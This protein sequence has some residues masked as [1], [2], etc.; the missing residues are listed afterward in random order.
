MYQQ[1]E[2]G[3]IQIN[4]SV[5]LVQR[6]SRS[7]RWN[8][9]SI[10]PERTT[11]I[12]DGESEMTESLH[13]PMLAQSFSNEEWKYKTHPFHI[14]NA[15]ERIRP[16]IVV[17]THRPFPPTCRELPYRSSEAGWP[18]AWGY[19]E[20]PF[21]SKFPLSYF[22]DYRIIQFVGLLYARR[23]GD[24]VFVCDSCSYSAMLG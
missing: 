3:C 18:A 13:S 6:N 10:L 21:S 1:D 5:D 20:P 19:R 4:R 2:G 17:R 9:G 14:M 24:S 12:G 23:G 8:A 22:E 15:V 16:V 7:P 11:T